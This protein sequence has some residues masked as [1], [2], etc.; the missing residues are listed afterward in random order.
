M[1]VGESSTLR[2]L[3]RMGGRVSRV[4]VIALMSAL[5]VCHCGCTNMREWRRNGYKVG[6]EYCPPA[7]PVAEDWIDSTS[8]RL[9]HEPPEDSQWWTAFNDPVLNNLVVHAYEQNLDLRTAGFR[10]MEARA[11]RAVTAGNLLPQTQQASADYQRIK[12]PQRLGRPAA[13]QYFSAWATDVN[14]AWELDFWGRFRRAVE[15][16]DA[17]LHASV[18]NYDD[19]LVMLLGDVGVT[20]VEIRTLQSRLEAARANVD[21]QQGALR[22]AEVRFNE[23]RSTKLDVFQAQ[24]NLAQTESAIPAL[25]LAL[26]RASNRLCIL[27]GTAPRDLEQELGIGPIPVPPIDVAVGMP[28]DL[29][30]RRPD[31]RRAERELAAQSARIGVATAELYPHIAITGTIGLEANDF[32][33]LFR[34]EAFAGS[35]GPSLRW[36]I[37]NYGRL[38]NDIRVQDARFQQLATQYQSTVLQANA[39][40]EDALAA[41]LKS[42]ERAATL[43]DSVE[44]AQNA[45]DMALRQYREGQIDFNRVFILQAALAREQDQ[46]AQVSGDVARSL[47]EIYRALGG[48]WQ[49]RYPEGEQLHLV[50]ATPTEGPQP[51]ASTN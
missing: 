35:I 3:T 20:Y 41:F 10:V 43:T 38:L 6:P 34:R 14:L 33:N 50:A 28:A 39:E 5:L 23:G 44:A 9:R 2:H 42:H 25:E 26:R 15:A 49:S 27:C 11:Q 8:V 17:D 47:V 16:A 40:A 32:T 18:E 37:L 4:A 24:N 48:G 7:V 1:Q 29:L 21:A 51:V 12:T 30:R 22:I 31:V 36:N 46:L 45:V 19:M 13:G